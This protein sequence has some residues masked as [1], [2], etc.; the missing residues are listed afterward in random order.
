MYSV[1]TFVLLA[2]SLIMFFFSRVSDFTEQTLIAVYDHDS[3]VAAWFQ[4]HATLIRVCRAFCR[5][6]VGY[7]CQN[8]AFLVN[9]ERWLVIL[10]QGNKRA[11]IASIFI[12]VLNALILSTLWLAKWKYF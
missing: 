7:L 2:L 12:L 8:L 1:A 9:T 4:D 11:F 6:L 3:L 5:I 10:Q